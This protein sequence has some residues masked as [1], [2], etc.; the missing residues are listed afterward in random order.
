MLNGGGGTWSTERN[1]TVFAPATIRMSTRRPL[2][3]I[4]L[5]TYVLKDAAPFLLLRAPPRLCFLQ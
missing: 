1:D 4:A 2:P 5:G 3:P